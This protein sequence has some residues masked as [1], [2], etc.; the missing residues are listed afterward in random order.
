M[1]AMPRMP[2]SIPCA[3]CR[4]MVY[5]AAVAWPSPAELLCLTC[6][7]QRLH[8]APAIE[9]APEQRTPPA[10]LLLRRD[11]GSLES[12]AREYE[13]ELRDARPGAGLS[14]GIVFWDSVLG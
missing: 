6:A 1:A 7:L 10:T 8:E 4:D 14:F 2:C 11:V 13:R 9:G 12:L 5:L 3:H